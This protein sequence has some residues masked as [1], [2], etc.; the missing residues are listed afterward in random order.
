MLVVMT[1]CMIPIP[2]LA[3][4]DA[5]IMTVECYSDRADMPQYY[6]FLYTGGKLHISGECVALFGGFQ[7]NGGKVFTRG[8]YR[9]VQDAVYHG[10]QY[11]FPLYETMKKMETAYV[12]ENGD[13]YFCSSNMLTAE[14]MTYVDKM[15]RYPAPYDEDSIVFQGGLLYSAVFNVTTEFRLRTFVKGYF[16]PVFEDII[17]DMAVAQTTTDPIYE[18]LASVEGNV[19]TPLAQ[20]DK[21]V[22]SLEEKLG[23]ESSSMYYSENVLED[24]ME[25]AAEYKGSDFSLAE[26]YQS[27]A[28]A[29]YA[30][31]L[32]QSYLKGLKLLLRVPAEDRP[33][34]AMEEAITDMF[35]VLKD[36]EKAEGW[37]Q[38][39]NLI[40][41]VFWDTTE[42]MAAIAI[43]KSLPKVVKMGIKLIEHSDMPKQTGAIERSAAF[44]IVQDQAEELVEDILSEDEI[45]YVELKYAL[46]LYYKA[47][48]MGYREYTF[49]DFVGASYQLE[50]EEL[51]EIIAQLSSVMDR[52]LENIGFKSTLL[53]TGQLEIYESEVTATTTTTTQ[54][55]PA[56]SVQP[57]ETTTTRKTKPAVEDAGQEA[58]ATNVYT[59][60]DSYRNMLMLENNWLNSRYLSDSVFD[61]TGSNA[62]VKSKGYVEEGTGAIGIWKLDLNSDGYAEL[63][64]FKQKMNG[65]PEL[66]L[67]IYGYKPGQGAQIYKLYSQTLMQAGSNRCFVEIYSGA[68]PH[69]AYMKHGTTYAIDWKKGAE[70][71]TQTE[72]P[73]DMGNSIAEGIGSSSSKYIREYGEAGTRTPVA[74]IDASGGLL[75]LHLTQGSD[76]IL[77][78]K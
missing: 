11:W 77:T 38:L 67:E 51:A 7:W 59:A 43:K 58:E 40:E 75:A 19:I 48:M 68:N 6:A 56:Q 74:I 47:A 29:T 53:S 12:V 64:M 63:V 25:V 60:L 23:L 13:F 21:Q 73:Q 14:F 76:G 78:R 26:F 41:N 2:A 22:D 49:D 10:G 45:D 69:I 1:L 8:D 65:M 34:E 42:K 5:R 62:R 46:I 66:T 36:R 28:C 4:A 55:R 15:K 72:Y 54:T 33:E 39:S 61:W 20:G 71:I 31:D 9:V 16:L 32:N 57:A 3:A 27:A 35:R 18:W 37:D 70:R 30:Y 44:A 50:A 17:Y 52:D 24:M